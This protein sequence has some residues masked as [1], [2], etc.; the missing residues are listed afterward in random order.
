MEHTTS[1]NKIIIHNP[2]IYVVSN[3]PTLTQKEQIE[4]T[5]VIGTHSGT[6]H[7]DEIVAIALYS[8]KS[9]YDN[10]YVVRTRDQEILDKCDFVVDYGGGAYDHHK[11]NSK[12][13][14]TKG[15]NKTKYASAGLVFSHKDLGF[16][17]IIIENFLLDANLS[18][19]LI[20]FL[21]KSG[22]S[23]KQIEAFI[24][25][26]EK[27]LPDIKQSIIDEIDNK[28]I[29]PVDARDTGEKL[30][31]PRKDIFDFIPS[32]NPSWCEENSS[33]NYNRKF[34]KALKTTR[35]ILQEVFKEEISKTLKTIL[36]E[37]IVKQS[38][39][40]E[41]S[42]PISANSICAKYFLSILPQSNASTSHSTYKT[43]K[44]GNNDLKDIWNNYS[45]Q[46][47]SNSESTI[48]PIDSIFN[49]YSNFK[50]DGTTNE[51]YS[52]VA[53]TI[54]HDLENKK[55]S[56]R[57]SL[58]NSIYN[59]LLNP[60][61]NN[62]DTSKNPLSFIDAFNPKLF[63]HTLDFKNMLENAQTVSTDILNEKMQEIISREYAKETIETLYRNPSF[64][65]DGI[66]ELPS[67]SIPW[68]E[69]VCLLNSQ[70]QD[71]TKSIDYVIFPYPDGG[72]AVQAV[73]PSLEE[74]FDK[75]FPILKEAMPKL[76]EAN[77][78]L[79]IHPGKF[80][81]RFAETKEDAIKLC[82]LSREIQINYLQLI[83]SW[84]AF[85][86]DD[87]L[88]LYEKD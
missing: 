84:K 12:E 79:W 41:T 27:K 37:D 2:N 35:L 28:I 56:I 1:S 85:Y 87:E 62:L 40:S 4:N 82:K 25:E 88:D 44:T 15:N 33:D 17:D 66:L 58:R 43:E 54:R 48:N 63:E 45:E 65:S 30:N 46:I 73:P 59:E 81:A 11:D 36:P 76:K 39:L 57:A 9:N 49:L 32:F 67:Q 42:K 21:K 10:I 8:F 3:I 13:R 52:S 29:I 77:P 75:R 86:N 5:L 69:T 31:P 68:K 6:F 24:S 34:Q 83:D 71:P 22:L 14:R 64:F 74:E 51:Q 26:F 50:A 20:R 38:P 18:D 16:S 72:W 70:T 61:I 53:S 78:K 55:E 60:I 47:I 7:A 80:F 23:D 19:S